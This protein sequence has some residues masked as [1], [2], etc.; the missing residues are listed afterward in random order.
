MLHIKTTQE[1]L[2]ENRIKLLIQM[3]RRKS[4]FFLVK[5]T[6]HGNLFLCFNLQ[7]LL[8]EILTQHHL[9]LKHIFT[10][11]HFYFKLI[12]DDITKYVK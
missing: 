3:Q 5:T 7:S 11:P 6:L 12:L 10:F 8:F 1:I 4:N 9:I 2:Y